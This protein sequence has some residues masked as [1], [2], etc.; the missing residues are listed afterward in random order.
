MESKGFDGRQ[1]DYASET[2]EL[3]DLSYKN[4][5]AEVVVEDRSQSWWK[6]F[7]HLIEVDNGADNK[8]DNVTMF[9]YNYDLRPVEEKR[10]TW[11][12]YNF[13]NFWIADAFNVN[14][15][16]I[17]ATGVQSGLTWWQT[18]ITIWLGYF[19]TGIFVCILARIGIYN[20][21][22]FPVT[23]RISFGLFGSLWPIINRVVMACVW[24]GLQAWIGGEC[25]TL[26]LKSIF[27]T[28][29]SSRMSSFPK[30][31]GITTDQFLG[32]FLFWLVSLPAMWFPPHQIRHLFTAKSYIVPFAGFGFL[33]WTL[34]KAHG[35]GPSI[36]EP[37]KLHGSDF[38]WAFVKSTMNAMANFATLITNSPDFSR[39]A[40]KPSKAI[41]Y[42]QYI[43]C[44]PI[45][46]SITCLIGILVS[47]ASQVLSS[48]GPFWDPLDLLNTFLGHYTSGNRAGVFLLSF[49]F[50]LAQL[51][52]NISANSLSFGTDVT[53]M[54]PRFLNIRRGSYL[55]A[56][57]GLCICPWRFM[58]KSSKFTTVLSAYAVF[59]SSICGVAASDYYAVRR[60]YVDLTSLF[61]LKINKNQGESDE[62]TEDSCYR[63]NRIGCNWRAYAAY[64]SGVLPNIVG[65]VGATGKP[66][67]AGAT[68]IYNLSFP[69][70]FF[71]A[72]LVYYLLSVV[73]FPI[74]KGIPEGVKPLKK[75]WYEEWKNVE[76]FDEELRSVSPKMSWAVNR[77]RSIKS[78][79]ATLREDI[80]D[81]TMRHP[82]PDW[83]STKYHKEEKLLKH[84]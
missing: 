3:N 83:S 2:Y 75:S 32:F 6:K 39:F 40:D 38:G 69:V 52:S 60:G 71:V 67:P 21:I 4:N 80:G 22:S 43:A 16:Q 84:E 27:G 30:S 46:F 47:S 51:G 48:D 11:S 50:A 82:I 18:W 56:A 62:S 78:N 31:E 74:R 8:F 19:I 55:C 61:S 26:M 72:F 57:L 76:Y 79:P 7:L 36:H 13:I 15:W 70:G 63:Y 81:L 12:W 25:V 29:L 58:T 66:V 59:L 37:T 45:T 42:W 65:F 28:N 49:S 77:V 9:L 54:V 34:L 41:K 14:T 17:A 5:L 53:A 23:I 10:R 1:G 24:F 64:V 44:I 20:H 73:L 33:I 35:A 68:K